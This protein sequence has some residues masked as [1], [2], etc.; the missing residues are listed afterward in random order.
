MHH[1]RARRSQKFTTFARWACRTRCTFRRRTRAQA[2]CQPCCAPQVVLNLIEVVVLSTKH[3]L[4]CLACTE[5]EANYPK[6]QYSGGVPTSPP[7]QGRPPHILRAHPDPAQRPYTS[8]GQTPRH[9]PSV[10]AARCC[11]RPHAMGMHPSHTRSLAKSMRPTRPHRHPLPQ[12][13]AFGRSQSRSSFNSN[14][15]IS[16]QMDRSPGRSPSD[17]AAAHSV[18]P[19][20][21]PQPLSQSRSSFSWTAVRAAAHQAEPQLTQLDRSPGRSPLV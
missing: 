5:S 16:T 12:T 17:R 6:A 8:G 1:P 7:F 10:T 19:Q 14:Y 20:S 18:G 2:C 21:G 11:W 9:S 15:R 3:S 4:P 13:R